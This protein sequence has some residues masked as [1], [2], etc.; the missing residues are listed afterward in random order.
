MLFRLETDAYEEEGL[1][2]MANRAPTIHEHEVE[3]ATT[4]ITIEARQE[5]SAPADTNPT[6]DQQPVTTILPE[7]VPV[8]DTQREAATTPYAVEKPPSP[9]QPSDQLEL[10]GVGEAA[11]AE[12]IIQQ[13][14]L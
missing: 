4:T 14:V 6:P 9:T 2:T 10:L 13:S 8:D 12:E 1:A 3:P 5:G 11:S 7:P